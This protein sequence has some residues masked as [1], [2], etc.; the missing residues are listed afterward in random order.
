[1]AGALPIATGSAD[2]VSR[3]G[4]SMSPKARTWG[5]VRIDG[6]GQLITA[7]PETGAHGVEIRNRNL[8]LDAVGRIEQV[9]DLT[10]TGWQRSADSLSMSFSLPPGWRLLALFGADQVQG[11]WLTSWT[12][13]D[14]FL[15]LIFALAVYRIWGIKA[16]L[17]ALLAFG[18]SY[19]EP[20]SPRLTWFFLLV[21]L[22]LLPLV[23][24]PTGSW[25]LK[26]WRNLALV[27][28]ALHL[29]P[30]VARQ[31]QSAIYPQLEVA[32]RNYGDRDV[33]PRPLA[34]AREAAVMNQAAF[35][36]D[37]YAANAPP[38]GEFGA[39]YGGEMGGYELGRLRDELQ[40]KR[41]VAARC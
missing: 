28:L 40:R 25:L 10:A 2:G 33:F 19:H 13:L 38:D 7:N 32:G 12:L 29:V 5:A 6:Q 30:F 20:Y 41:S 26:A 36:G 34:P 35:D 14:L 37:S 39:G 22:A 23:T 1:M 11:D 4:V 3:F 8:N 18:L 15:T 31:V 27:L 21:P 16:G 9:A 24:A 17:V